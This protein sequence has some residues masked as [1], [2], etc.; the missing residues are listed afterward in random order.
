[1][2]RALRQR[3]FAPIRAVLVQGISP[4]KIALSIAIGLVIGIFPVLGTTTVLCTL[5]ALSLRL[6]LVAVHAVHYA[7]TPLQLMAAIPFVRL[8]EHLL[9]STPQPLS[10]TEATAL[11]EAGLIPAVRELWEAIV[12]AIVGW[13][14]I[15]PFAIALTYFVA[16]HALERVAT[17]RAKAAIVPSAS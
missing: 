2:L 16:A 8:G 4:R 7:A 9:G 3:V 14:A 10:I 12:H 5:A 11:V 1:M 17:A 6:N 13:I 15:G